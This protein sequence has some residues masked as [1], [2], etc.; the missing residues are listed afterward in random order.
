MLVEVV[1]KHFDSRDGTSKVFP[2]YAKSQQRRTQLADGIGLR[3]AP[4][5]RS[6]I[7]SQQIADRHAK[8]LRQ[9]RKLLDRRLPLPHEHVAD[10]RIIQTRSDRQRLH[11]E[12]HVVHARPEAFFPVLVH[13]GWLYP[14]SA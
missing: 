14:I 4:L 9:T 1:D 11:S 12:A 10:I 7:L 5:G 3:C 8:D 6:I 13:S 2:I